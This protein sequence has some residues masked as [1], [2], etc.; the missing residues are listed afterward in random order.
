[1]A[2]GVKNIHR[3][4]SCIVWPRSRIQ[5]AGHRGNNT[6]I[7]TWALRGLEYSCPWLS[8]DGRW[9]RAI[10]IRDA[11]P[12]SIASA[13]GACPRRRPKRIFQRLLRLENHRFA[14]CRF[15]ADHQSFPFS[16]VRPSMLN[17]TG[18]L[19][20][21]W[22]GFEICPD[23]TQMVTACRF[24]CSTF[25]A[26]FSFHGIFPRDGYTDLGRYGRREHKD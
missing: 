8:G 23:T 9:M 4:I 15:R 7:I 22:P 19:T 10:E 11:R 25:A 20:A 1:M 26:I 12:A 13:D 18:V 24:R 17:G 21:S 2:R 3:Q 16:V 6:R 14:R 5:C